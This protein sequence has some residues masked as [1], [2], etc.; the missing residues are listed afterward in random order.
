MG[1]IVEE[2]RRSSLASTG[3]S[4][5][6]VVGGKLTRAVGFASL[7]DIQGGY[8]GLSLWGWGQ[9]VAMSHTPFYA[10]RPRWSQ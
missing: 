2:E 8:M 9:V 10:L 4:S 1:S 6:Y 5:L 3:H 7:L